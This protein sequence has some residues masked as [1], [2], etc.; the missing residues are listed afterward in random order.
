MKCF[1]LDGE[2]A[3][4]KFTIPDVEKKYYQEI[5][6]TLNQL[7]KFKEVLKMGLIGKVEIY[8]YQHIPMFHAQCTDVNSS[9]GRMTISN[10]LTGIKRAQ[11][12]VIQFSKQTYPKL[13]ETYWISIQEIIKNSSV[14][15]G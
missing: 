1:A 13:F 9:E 2:W 12:P 15:K 6:E 8:T 3:L 10:Y 14:W 11:C 5:P 7:N 4:K